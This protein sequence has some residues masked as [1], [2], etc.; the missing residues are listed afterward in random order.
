M[1][2]GLLA[3]GAGVPAALADTGSAAGNEDAADRRPE[4]VPRSDRPRDGAETAEPS[5][6]KPTE[7]PGEPEDK[8]GEEPDDGDAEPGEVKI[9]GGRPVG[10]D[11][12]DGEVVSEE[13]P[14]PCC[15]DGT[16]DCGPGWPWPW[17]WPWPG[18]DDPGDLPTSDGDYGENR[19]ETVPPIRPMPP[20][21]GPESPDVLDVVPGIGAG[22]DD[23]TRAPISVPI[24]ITGPPVGVA[25]VP[26]P[27]VGAGPAPGGAGPPAAPRQGVRS[28]A[29]PAPRP[30]VPVP[31]GNSV[32]MPGQAHRAGYAESLRTAGLP[33]LAAL[34]LPGLA[35]ILVLTGAGGLLGY[36]QA[37]AGQRLRPSGIARFIN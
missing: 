9:P 22:P 12:G 32:A 4:K 30:P 5:G 13:A 6:D 28:Q 24:I 35:G 14:P 25:P 1:A 26:G 15:T 33:Q 34:A 17:P 23:G 18:P 21:G 2:T 29:P 19:P 3:G 37:R 8:P 36:R 16:D 27:A 10:E 11:D 7:K 20:M 31:P